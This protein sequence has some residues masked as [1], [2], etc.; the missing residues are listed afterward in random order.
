[1]NDKSESKVAPTVVSILTHSPLIN[2]PVQGNLVRQHK[3]IFEHLP[4]IFECV[5]LAQTWMDLDVLAQF[6]KK[7]SPRDDE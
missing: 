7:T 5:K 3:G 2:D 6:E 1:M 4:E